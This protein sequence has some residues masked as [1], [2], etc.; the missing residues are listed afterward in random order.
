MVNIVHNSRDLSHSSGELGCEINSSLDFRLS[1]IAQQNV[2]TRINMGIGRL[3][4]GA[5]L[6]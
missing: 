3:H 1:N 4:C 6:A 2:E 5:A